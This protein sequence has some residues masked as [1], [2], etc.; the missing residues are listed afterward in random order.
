MKVKEEAQAEID[1][2]PSAKSLIGKGKGSAI[3]GFTIEK[4]LFSNTFRRL[5]FSVTVMLLSKDAGQA[6]AIRGIAARHNCRIHNVHDHR[7]DVTGVDEQSLQKFL[8]AM[9]AA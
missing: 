9:H 5:H 2:L 1:F 4:P 8:N 3:D 7:L 6:N